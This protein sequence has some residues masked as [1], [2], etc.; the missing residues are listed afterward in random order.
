[1]GR[2]SF[3]DLTGP[4]WIRVDSEESEPAR[5]GSTDGQSSERC[6]QEATEQ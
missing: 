6:R 3:G 1:M 5:M 4:G 2:R